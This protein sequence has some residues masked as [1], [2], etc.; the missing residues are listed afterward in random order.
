[1]TILRRIEFDKFKNCAATFAKDVYIPED[2]PAH[3]TLFTVGCDI[4][5]Q[6]EEVNK[7]LIKHLLCHPVSTE[8]IAVIKTAC[9]NAWAVE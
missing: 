8:D 6:L 5:R 1:M 7:H 4:D 2:G 3:L 9:A